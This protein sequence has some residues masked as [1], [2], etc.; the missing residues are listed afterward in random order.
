M[1]QNAVGTFIGFGRFFRGEGDSFIRRYDIKY[2]NSFQLQGSES[3]L[4]N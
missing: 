3:E 1:E 4:T 2:S